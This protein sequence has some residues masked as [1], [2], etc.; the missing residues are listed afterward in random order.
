MHNENLA[1]ILSPTIKRS[2]AE[3]VAER[4]RNAILNGQLEPEEPLRE[5]ALSELM[6]VSR[7][8]VREA[9]NH[10]EREGLVMVTPTGRTYVARLSRTDFD[11][12]FSLRR[13]LERLAIEYACQR[14]TPEDIAAVQAVVDAMASAIDRGI[15]EKEAAEL[16]L[17]FHDALYAASRLNA[18]EELGPEH[19]GHEELEKFREEAGVQDTSKKE[20]RAALDSILDLSEMNPERDEE[21]FVVGLRQILEGFAKV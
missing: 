13:A 19:P 14:A 1:Q 7:G 10:L 4:L 11:E 15:D 6:G 16:D 2:L 9:L 12:V 20:T 5:A 18:N 21:L 17:Q 8:P 3:E